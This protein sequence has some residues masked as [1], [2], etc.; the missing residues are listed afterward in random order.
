MNEQHEFLYK[1]QPT[2]PEML[3]EGPTD[4]ESELVAQHFDYLKGLL[5]RGILILAGRTQNSDES[6]FGIVVF[7]AASEEQALMMMQEDPAMKHGVMRAALF[8]YKVA[9]MGK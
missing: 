8:P 2:R 9:L 5:E 3:T 1:I 6:S 7:R 4:R